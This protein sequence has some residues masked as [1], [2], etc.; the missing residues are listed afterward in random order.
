MLTLLCVMERTMRK[1]SFAR[2]R[3][4]LLSMISMP[5]LKVSRKHWSWSQ[6]TW[7]LKRSL[8]PQRRRLLIDVIRRE[9]HMLSCFNSVL[10]RFSLK[11]RAM[12]N[13]LPT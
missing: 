2:V 9:E 4:I 7:G 10:R 12:V 8:L 6:M 3:H 5:L 11:R 13:C 1:L